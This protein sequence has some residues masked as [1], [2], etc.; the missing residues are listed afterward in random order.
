MVA[1]KQIAD[2]PDG[3]LTESAVLAR[4][5]DDDRGGRKKRHSGLRVTYPIAN[6]ICCDARKSNAMLERMGKREIRP[7]QQESR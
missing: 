3:S 4:G 7:Q 6:S 2:L 1:I 5:H